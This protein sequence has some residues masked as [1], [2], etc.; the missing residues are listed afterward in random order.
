MDTP[1]K[2]KVGFLKQTDQTN[3]VLR[4]TITVER[5]RLLLCEFKDLNI[6]KIYRCSLS[7]FLQFPKICASE[8]LQREPTD[9]PDAITSTIPRKWHPVSKRWRQQLEKLT[10]IDYSKDVKVK[11]FVFVKDEEFC[12][13]R[14]NAGTEVFLGLTID[15]TEDRRS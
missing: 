11:S 9:D 4:Y 3:V 12:I 10:N 8:Y 1:V 7:S 14:G 2:I 15:G 5:C 13:A 6:L